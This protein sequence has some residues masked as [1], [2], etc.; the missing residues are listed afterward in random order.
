MRLLEIRSIR[1]TSRPYQPL[2]SFTS[3]LAQ[4]LGLGAAS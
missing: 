2:W 3:Q 1:F 4:N